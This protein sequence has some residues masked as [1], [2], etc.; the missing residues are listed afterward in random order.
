MKKIT[1]LI[2]AISFQLQAQSLEDVVKASNKFLE[3]L[4]NEQLKTAQFP[5]ENKDRT[6]WTNLPIGLK[7]RDGVRIGDIS[8]SSKTA[9]HRLLT[10]VLSS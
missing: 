5:F 9:L 4:G 8:A 1:L 3:S 7:P 2:L 10:T 6:S